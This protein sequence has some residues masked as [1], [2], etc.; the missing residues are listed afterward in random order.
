SRPASRSFCR[1]SFR[2][3]PPPAPAPAPPPSRAARGG[4]AA[5]AR[6]ASLAPLREVL[7]ADQDLAGLGALAGTDDAILFHHVDEARGLGV[8]EAEAPLEKGDRS[9]ALGDHEGDRVPV[10]VVPVLV[11]AAARFGDRG[12]SDLLVDRRAL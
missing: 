1:R 11:A 9:G 6:S 3:H 8:A 7:G 2:A 4:R 12:Q 10:D 5:P